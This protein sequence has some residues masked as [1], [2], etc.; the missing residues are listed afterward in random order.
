MFLSTYHT[1]YYLSLLICVVVSLSTM[2]KLNPGFRWLSILVVLTL[3][4]EIVA[5]YAAYYIDT[6]N[7]AV[8]HVFTPIEFLF[9]TLVYIS[10]VNDKKWTKVFIFCWIF[11]LFSEI[12][13]TIYVQPLDLSNTNVM[14]MESVML[15]FYSLVLFLKIKESMEYDNLLEEGIFWFNSMMLIYY[16][17]NILIWGFHS[18]KIYNLT[19]PP[20][21][22]YDVNLI[23]SGVLYLVLSFALFLNYKSVTK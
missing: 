17:A 7:S 22:I 3:I 21:L 9:Y 15:V 23:L 11:L 13:N 16:A 1:F 8:Y 14:I 2:S 20:T 18:I 19:N 6:T 4:V 12:I 5:K 10:L